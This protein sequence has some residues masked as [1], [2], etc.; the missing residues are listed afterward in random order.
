MLEYKMETREEKIRRVMGQRQKGVIV[1]EDIHDPHNAMAVC[2]TAEGFG[3]QNIYLIFD[4]EV[5]F[6]PKKIGKASSS[7]A[8]KWLDFKIFKSAKECYK[9]LKN[10]KYEIWATV[11]EKEAESLLESKLIKEKIAIVIGNEHRGLSKMAINLA[12]KK[13]YIPMRGMVQSFNLS[14]TA[15]IIMWEITRQR[16]DEKK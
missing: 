15:A 16:Y 14:V 3:F 11:L 5:G 10:E 13:L 9:E 1:L 7:S 12:D 2:R 6:D 4:K 8:N